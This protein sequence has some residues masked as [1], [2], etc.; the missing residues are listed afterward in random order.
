MSERHLGDPVKVH[1]VGSPQSRTTLQSDEDPLE[2]ELPALEESESE[3]ECGGH[4]VGGDTFRESEAEG[5]MDETAVAAK[6]R[7]R[8]AP[9]ATVC[10]EA[11]RSRGPN[12]NLNKE[13]EV[14]NF[15]LF[16]GNWG[17]N[18]YLVTRRRG[19]GAIGWTARS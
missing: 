10:G 2:K 15:G 13:P 5:V 1:V 12:S 6:R 18:V 3:S 17:S 9:H 16:F 4:S 14:G 8:E 7:Q 11:N 19:G